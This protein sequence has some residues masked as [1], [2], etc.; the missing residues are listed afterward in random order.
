MST[1]PLSPPIHAASTLP[2]AGGAAKSVTC[3]TAETH[4]SGLPGGNSGLHTRLILVVNGVFLVTMAIFL[5]LSYAA[6][7]R[8]SFDLTSKHLDETVGV[9]A[10]Q[11]LADGVEIAEIEHRLSSRT[12]VA[13]HVLV[14]GPGANIRRSSD[15]SLLG[16]DFE[17][18]FGL[19]AEIS[20]NPEWLAAEAALE[21][22]EDLRVVL[23]R[24]RAGE[25]QFLRSFVALHGAHVLV[26]MALFTLLL[27]LAGNCY[28][29]RP[30]TRLA[31][32]V[33]RLER[34][35]HALPAAPL[36][37]DEL[38]W[39]EGRFARMAESLHVTTRRM[40]RAEKQASASAVV[41]RIVRELEAPLRSMDRHTA[42][43]EGLSAN[44]PELRRVE[45][46]IREDR[47]HVLDALRRLVEIE[48][49]AHEAESPRGAGPS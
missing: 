26:T 8:R 21:A 33:E 6:E 43:L 14:V 31:H 2:E 41:F 22:S 18:Q 9:L 13:H 11:P 44:D 47:R 3:S 34:G 29:R 20:N 15:P 16:R 38:G 17:S 27:Q 23:L 24:M 45:E 46:E 12:G 30:I 19:G 25:E 48:E 1:F 37:D 35:E 49:T 28:V 39:L 10:S 32:L 40:V 4:P 36:H 5:S 7:S 42:Y